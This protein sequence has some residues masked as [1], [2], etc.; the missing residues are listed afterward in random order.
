M[1]RKRESTAATG[2]KGYIFADKV[3]AAFLV[4]MLSRIAPVEPSLGLISEIHFETEESGRSLDDL[5]LLFQSGRRHCS[6][7]NFGQEQ[8]AALKSGFDATFVRDAWTEW[9]NE[10]VSKFDQN[11]DLLGLVTGVVGDRPLQD[12]QNV[13]KEIADTTPDR[14]LLRLDGPKQVSSS[15][16]RILMSLSSMKQANQVQRVE[17]IRLAGRLHVQHFNESKD[18][19]RCINQCAILV[20]SGTIGD[21][22]NLWNTLC[23]LAADNRGTGGYFDVPELI[24]MFGASTWSLSGFRA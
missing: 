19:G 22:T 14:F 7:A 9:R 6:L 12:W 5:I 21:G 18:E 2:G 1:P 13:R 11:S 24:S 15:K 16:R 3:A 4:Q 8:S 23:Q 20:T 17:T 10:G